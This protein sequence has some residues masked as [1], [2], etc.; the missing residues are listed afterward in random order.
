MGI[1]AINGQVSNE[2]RLLQSGLDTARTGGLLAVVG[3][4]GLNGQGPV[5]LLGQKDAND[6]VRPGHRPK[7]NLEIGTRQEGIPVPI[8]PANGKDDIRHAIILPGLQLCAEVGAGHGF[9]VLI[10]NDDTGILGNVGIQ[11][12]GFLSLAVGSPLGPAFRQLLQ[13]DS[14]HTKSAPGLAGTI[15]IAV[16]Q[17][18][19]G[20]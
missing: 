16:E 13:G 20:A 9:S 5:D 1:E 14:R 15:K 2:N 12:R 3:M 17:F 4:T 7:S 10:Q 18:L 19:V 8:G 6:L 11:R